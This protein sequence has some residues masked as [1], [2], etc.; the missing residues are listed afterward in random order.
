[1]SKVDL[2]FKA[3]TL[4]GGDFYKDE[5]KIGR[6]VAAIMHDESSTDIP[7]LK[8][9]WW[10]LLMNDEPIEFETKE[11][12]EAFKLIVLRSSLPD[13]A[14]VQIIKAITD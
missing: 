1:M 9:K 10:S 8:E 11:E 3:K 6:I 13:G 12:A 14:K 2:N 4:S 7:L 5:V